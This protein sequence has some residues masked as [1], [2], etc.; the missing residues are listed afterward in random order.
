MIREL[1]SYLRG[2]A[3]FSQ[4]HELQSL[5]GWIRRRLRCV[6]WVQW[7]T[8]GRRVADDIMNSGASEYPGRRPARPFSAQG[9]MAND[10]AFTNARFKSMG[11]LPMETLVKA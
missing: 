9:T 3:G 5:D 10:R 6:A 11:L 2:W 4:W 8:R 1:V 7:K